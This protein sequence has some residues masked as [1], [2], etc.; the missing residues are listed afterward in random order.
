MTKHLLS[1][2]TGADHAFP[3]RPQE[4]SFPGV[5]CWKAPPT[6]PARDLG[7]F[8]LKD[9]FTRVGSPIGGTAPGTSLLSFQRRQLIFHQLRQGGAV[10]PRHPLV[11]LSLATQ[12]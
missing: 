7:F 8:P 11:R 9:R 12:R 10:P 3:Q 4:D 2:M 1:S 6:V 5:Q